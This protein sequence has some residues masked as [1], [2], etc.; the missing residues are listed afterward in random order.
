MY[1]GLLFLTTPTAFLLGFALNVPDVETPFHKAECPPAPEVRA[2]PHAEM[3][4]Q[5]ERLGMEADKTQDM[6]IELTKR[7]S[8]R[9]SARISAVQR[10]RLRW[11]K[12]QEFKVIECSQGADMSVFACDCWIY[13]RCEKPKSLRERFR[14][15]YDNVHMRDVCDCWV[16][17]EAPVGSLCHMFEDRDRCKEFKTPQL[18]QECWDRW[19][20]EIIPMY[21]KLD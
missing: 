21:L 15:C 4:L 19:E 8:A 5:L 13:G 17:D 2:D 14:G 6:V 12:D 10:E 3:R 7:E 11:E 9:V 16:Y 20:H 1:R 18:R